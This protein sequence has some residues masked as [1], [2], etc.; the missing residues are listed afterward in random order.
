MRLFGLAA[1][2]LSAVA[3]AA[4]RPVAPVP[5]SPLESRSDCPA[6]PSLRMARRGKPAT[7]NRLGDEPAAA[8]ELAVYR[9]VGG[10]QTPAILRED[11]GYTTGRAP[12]P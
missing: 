6:D 2:C 11:I 8:S 9:H 7:V 4:P 10:C 1:L 3:S 5:Q 12:A